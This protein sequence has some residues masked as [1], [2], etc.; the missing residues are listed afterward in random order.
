MLEII[1]ELYTSV[2]QLLIKV[3]ISAFPVVNALFIMGSGC[4]GVLLYKRLKPTAKEI[5]T[6]CLGLAVL[7]LGFSELWECLFVLEDGKLEITGT[8]LV[9]FSLLIGLLFGYALNLDGLLEKLGIAMRRVFL[10]DPLE[11]AAV[12][13]KIKKEELPPELLA[14]QIIDQKNCAEGFTM[15]TVMCGFSSLLITNFLAGRMANDP[16]PLLIKLGFDF[17]F[18][19]ILASIYGSGVPFAG[20]IVLVSEGVLGL[21]YSRWGDILLP[22]D[23]LDQIA[24]IGAVILLLCGASLCFGKKLRPANLIPA[25]FIPIIY[26]FFMTKIEETVKEKTEK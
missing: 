9:I 4:L 10:G 21:V 2:I 12:K 11:K 16:I 1:R 6:R 18:V 25:L 7:L 17:V 23:V 26:T 8:M 5:M 15:A 13:G 20:A 22:I 3:L 24:L 19:F 14:A